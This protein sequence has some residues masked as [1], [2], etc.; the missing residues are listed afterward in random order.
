MP[1]P[2]PLELWQQIFSSLTSTDINSLVLT[3]R[4]FYVNFTNLL[5]QNEIKKNGGH[6][7]LL[8]AA[9]TG[10]TRTVE[11]LLDAERSLQPC[12]NPK[13]QKGP[14]INPN[15][16]KKGCDSWSPLA[17]ASVRGFEDMVKLLLGMKNIDPNAECPRG[18]T[19]LSYAAQQGRVGT[20]KLLLEAGA[21]P[22]SQAELERTPLYWAG[23]PRLT[24][25]IHFQANEFGNDH[26]G[27]LFPNA[28]CKF[29]RGE[30]IFYEEEVESF[31]LKVRN[32]AL[33]IFT[34][35]DVF[36]EKDVPGT[37]EWNKKN[38][39]KPFFLPD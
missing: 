7:V 11:R 30:D 23:T 21:D 12:I 37:E 9:Q 34:S 16:P 18:R 8:Y 14:Q 39:H 22:N 20:V 1:C 2:L 27:T 19:P 10:S 28:S 33:P 26:T 38:S 32:S 17:W 15:S 6:V 29:H 31:R 24:R 4:Y 35:V 3:S 13:R 25:G 5:Y 36:F